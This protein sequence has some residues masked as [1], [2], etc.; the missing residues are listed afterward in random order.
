MSAIDPADM[1]AHADDTPAASLPAPG[2][3]AVLLSVGILLWTALAATWLTL[4]H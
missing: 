2:V 1:S 3:M 4:S